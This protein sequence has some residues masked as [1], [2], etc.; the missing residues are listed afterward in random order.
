MRGERDIDHD[1]GGVQLVLP[2]D[3]AERGSR[4]DGEAGRR[5]AAPPGFLISKNSGY[6]AL[7]T[8]TSLRISSTLVDRHAVRYSARSSPVDGRSAC[9]PRSDPLC[10]GCLL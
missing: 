7:T 10:D 1:I 2:S 5:H 8:T 9:F 6:R 3:S 4:H